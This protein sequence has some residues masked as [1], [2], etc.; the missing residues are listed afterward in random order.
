MPVYQAKKPVVV[1]WY[2]DRLLLRQG[3]L[4]ALNNPKLVKVLETNPNIEEVH[5]DELI[6]L[7][8]PLHLIKQPEDPYRMRKEEVIAELRSYG[9]NVDP[10][11]MSHTLSLQLQT[12][13]AMLKRNFVTVLDKLGRP[14]Y[15]DSAKLEVRKSMTDVDETLPEPEDANIEE[16]ETVEQTVNAP[17]IVEITEHVN[18]K[19]SATAES[20][21]KRGESAMSIDP[22][23]T[24]AEI[25]NGV[26]YSEWLRQQ[27]EMAQSEV[28]RAPVENEKDDTRDKKIEEVD[29]EET[30]EEV[31]EDYTIKEIQNV[32]DSVRET[33]RRFMQHEPTEEE[34]E[35]WYKV[36]WSRVNLDVA[37]NILRFNGIELEYDEGLGQ[38]K[39]WLIIDN[40][41]GFIESSGEERKWLFATNALQTR[42]DELCHMEPNYRSMTHTGIKR[43]VTELGKYGLDINYTDATNIRHFARKAFQ[44][45]K[46]GLQCPETEEEINTLLIENKRSAVVK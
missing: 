22:D 46:L 3:Q 44:I 40:L 21:I 16:Y 17:N 45:A 11:Q 14:V 43:K 6:R 35:K 42:H 37:E 36:H 25:K 30:Y 24:E 39:R 33:G 19:V 10:Y 27:T 9:I 31:K 34:M 2:Y 7:A 20:R 26:D 38:E 12:A 41:K 23:Y 29:V 28:F 1:T 5:D 32:V 4:V 18:K 13:R 8:P 15:V